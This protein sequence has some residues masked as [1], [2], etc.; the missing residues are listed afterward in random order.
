MQTE[1]T[2]TKATT[3]TPRTKKVDTTKIDVLSHSISALDAEIVRLRSEIQRTKLEISKGYKW[4]KAVK[5][6]SKIKSKKVMLSTTQLRDLRLKLEELRFRLKKIMYKR[7][8][9]NEE[10][11]VM[12]RDERDQSRFN[13]E[14]LTRSFQAERDP[15]AFFK[16][17]ELL[18]SDLPTEVQSELKGLPERYKSEP[19][20]A[21][22]RLLEII[23]DPYPGIYITLKEN[24]SLSKAFFQHIFGEKPSVQTEVKA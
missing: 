22:D 14:V 4:D 6:E 3:T 21:K 8:I 12:V 19:K 5:P 15:I 9:K 20:Q 1:T 11:A 7:V 23:Q 10:H 13:R 16:R 24:S 18:L 2:A 17:T